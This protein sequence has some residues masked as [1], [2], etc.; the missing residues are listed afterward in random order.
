MV[1][2]LL[3]ADQWRGECLSCLA[4]LMLIPQPGCSGARRPVYSAI[5]LPR[6][7]PVRRVAVRCIP[8]CT[9]KTIAASING[10]PLDDRFSNWA[11][12]V[13]AAGYQPS[14]FGYTDSAIDPRGLAADDPSACIITVN[15]CRASPGTP[16]CSMKCRLNGSSIC[17]Q[18]GYPILGSTVELL[19]QCTEPGV[20][21]G[22]GGESVLPLAIKAEDHETHYMVDRCIDWIAAQ[23]DPWITH[24]SLLRP[25][26]PFAARNPITA[27][28]PAAYAGAVASWPARAGGRPA[29]VAGLLHQSQQVPRPR[30]SAPD[31]AGQGELL[32]PD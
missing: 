10:A 5:I 3:T 25:H 13:S 7:R 27:S 12:E 19:C 16:R 26:P 9:C 20:D 28:R 15:H 14:L 30:C 18:K 17:K 1:I 6:R 2:H 29:P 21:W 11:R 23:Q 4:T 8:A 24:L 31:A 32:R 22:Q